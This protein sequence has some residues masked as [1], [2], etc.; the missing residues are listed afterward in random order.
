MSCSLS[1]WLVHILSYHKLKR[2]C[3]DTCLHVTLPHGTIPVDARQA[4]QPPQMCKCNLPPRATSPHSITRIPPLV[5]CR[6]E[7]TVRIFLPASFCLQ[8]ASRRLGP[9]ARLHCSP[10]LAVVVML[11]TRI[12]ISCLLHP[13]LS[14]PAALPL[15]RTQPP[16]LPHNTSRE[17][18]PSTLVL[19]RATTSQRSLPQAHMYLRLCMFRHGVQLQGR[20]R[21][22]VNPSTS[23]SLRIT[24]PVWTWRQRCNRCS[25]WA[26]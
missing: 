5:L 11:G 20:S 15:L 23:E 12:R 7:E 9:L 6:G 14:V 8:A 19:L 2:L 22:P 10:L 13:P 4:L 21:M 3:C 1:L 16:H 25:R 24:R 26:S 18:A 17:W